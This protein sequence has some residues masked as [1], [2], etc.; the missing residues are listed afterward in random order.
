MQEVLEYTILACKRGKGGHHQSLARSCVATA[1]H[2]EMVGQCVSSNFE[3]LPNL[4]EVRN[5]AP[6]NSGKKSIILALSRLLH[7]RLL[8]MLMCVPLINTPAPAI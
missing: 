8:R 5:G 1:I 2:D 6:C 3:L 4:S 7:G